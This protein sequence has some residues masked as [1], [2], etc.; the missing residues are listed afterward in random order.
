MIEKTLVMLKPDA[1]Q[2]AVTGEILTRF[3]KAGFKIIALKMIWMD[4]KLS[5]DHYSAV[6]DKEWFLE[7]EKYMT[8]GPVLAL[9]LEGRNA[10]SAIRKLVGVTRPEDAAPGTIRGDFAHFMGDG[11]NLIHASASESDA[12]KE[13]PLWFTDDEIHTYKR[14]DENH[15]QTH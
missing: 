8:E 2:R 10:I 4:S 6:V 15:V 13:I 14:A 9:I 5:R 3:E 12:L 1:V 11:R 7:Y